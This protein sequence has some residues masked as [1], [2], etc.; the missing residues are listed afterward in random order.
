MEE[1]KGGKT[2]VHGRSGGIMSVFPKRSI[3][4][5]EKKKD[6]REIKVVFR[7]MIK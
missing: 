1:K 3:K 5:K 6:S 2:L 7:G 4:G